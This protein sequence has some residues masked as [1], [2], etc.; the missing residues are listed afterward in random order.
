M[1]IP[2]SFHRYLCWEKKKAQYTNFYLDPDERRELIEDAGVNGLVLFEYYLHMANQKDG[3]EAITDE[4]AAHWFG[5][6]IH[7]AKRHRINLANT[8]WVLTEKHK[9]PGGTNTFQYYL[10]KSLVH[11]RKLQLER[12]AAG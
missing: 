5:W 8:G 11:E 6:T 4:R 3:N 12:P 1:S 9:G 2:D 7:T 10:G